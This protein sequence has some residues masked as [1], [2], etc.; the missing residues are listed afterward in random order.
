MFNR[1]QHLSVVDC[2]ENA[3]VSLQYCG[4]R[5]NLPHNLYTNCAAS[6]LAS[7][8]SHLE[9]SNHQRWDIYTSVLQAVRPDVIV[10][11]FAIDPY[12]Q[13]YR[14]ISHPTNNLPIKSPSH[15][16]LTNRLQF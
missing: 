2:L 10:I 5:R 15:Q 14:L 16:Q 4:P 12:Q 13:Q 7:S 3:A 8:D 1:Y 11:T 6:I 9:G